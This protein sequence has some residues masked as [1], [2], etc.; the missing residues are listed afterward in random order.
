[1][2]VQGAPC[3]TSNHSRSC[4]DNRCLPDAQD[5]TAIWQD[6]LHAKFGDVARDSSL[7]STWSCYNLGWRVVVVQSQDAKCGAP[8]QAASD[9]QAKST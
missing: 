3:E 1:M 7:L 9:K 8:P 5:V 4:Q 2:A 6:P